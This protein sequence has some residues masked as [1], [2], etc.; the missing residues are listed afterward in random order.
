MRRDPDSIK[1]RGDA[2]LKTLPDG[3]QD[4]LF[5]FLRHNTQRK[6]LVW[7]HDLHGVDSSTAAL[8]EF[9][10]WY[11]KARTIRQSARA[12][13]RLE[14]ALT[15]LPLLKVTAAQ[16]REIAQVEFELQAS[17]DRD[18]KL[19]AMLTKGERE[20]ERLRLEREKFEWAKKSEAEKGLDA[21]H[22]EIKGDAEALRIFEQLRAR[23]GQ[24][25]EGKS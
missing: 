10:Q 8:S 24:I 11:P 16:A 23:V 25:Q 1:A 17:E 14:D 19:M 2:T 6:T 18:P 20:R 7:L 21:L 9:F 5:V 22:A 15:K 4:E 3:I 12:A 13:S